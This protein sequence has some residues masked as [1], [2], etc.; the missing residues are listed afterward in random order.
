M[1]VH[2]R[3]AIIYSFTHKQLKAVST[4]LNGMHQHSEPNDVTE[5]AEKAQEPERKHGH[6]EQSGTDSTAQQ[7]SENMATMSSQGQNPL[8][9]NP[10]KTWP[11]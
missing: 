3:E 10:M 9:R 2:K 1:P 7:F 11:Q 5:Q 4:Y 8:H 6:N